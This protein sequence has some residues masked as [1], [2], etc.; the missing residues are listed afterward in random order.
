MRSSIKLEILRKL[1]QRRNA[2]QGFTLIELMI[3]VAI[4][5]LLGAVALPQ[6]LGARAAA[7]AG[8]KIGEIVG[9]SK[10]CAVY[11]ASG[12][13]GNQPGT[14][15]ATN[16]TAAYSASWSPSVAGLNCL[17]TT[18]GNTG[19]SRATITVQT[20]GAMSCAFN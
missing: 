6:F 3:V 8:A 10:E 4:V 5:G 16:Q 7:N 15:C 9:Q 14:Q 13:V 18:S 19:T 1:R 2:A 12:G 11:V 20:T 17:T